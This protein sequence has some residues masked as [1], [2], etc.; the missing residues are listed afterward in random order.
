[1]V[2]HRRFWG[3]VSDRPDTVPIWLPGGISHTVPLKR[4]HQLLAD[5]LH[6]TEMEVGIF[7]TGTGFLFRCP[8][9]GNTERN[10]QRMEPACTGPSWRNEH[11]LEPMVLVS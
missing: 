6:R 5:P 7:E 9:C 2:R 11:P 1:M 4:E 3:R 8:I 10:D